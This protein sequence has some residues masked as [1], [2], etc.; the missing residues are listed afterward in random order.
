MKQIIDNSPRKAILVAVAETR[1]GEK[2]F[3]ELTRLAETAGYQTVATLFQRRDKPDKTYHIGKGKLS[4]LL[5]IVE[6]QSA[7]IVIFDDDISG[8]KFNNL[9]QFL[10]VDVIDR[11]T[12]ILEIF[13]NRAISGE[14]KLQIELAR[15]KNLLPRIIGKGISLSRQG[16]GGAGGGGARRG[17][18]E[19]KLEL[20]RRT[21]REEIDVLTEKI[22]K[23]SKER[24][25][26]RQKR[27]KNQIKT[28]AIVGYTNAGK[29][30][31]MNTLTKADVLSDDK[32][33]ATLDPISRKLWLDLGKEF[34]LVDTVGFISRLPHE[35]VEAFKST[36][37]EAKFADLLVVVSDGSS[38][39]VIFE[40]DSVCDTLDNIGTP[41]ETPRI[42][43]LNKCDKGLVTTIPN[44][45]HTVVISAKTGEG[46]DLLK[47]KI[48][49][50]LFGN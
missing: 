12:L 2:V 43:A 40:Y 18:G 6:S 31:L 15:N 24:D 10:N 25:L 50:L 21:L 47:S 32:L 37:E 41:A 3:A 39:S 34:L 23:L 35:L 33:F 20:D 44:A 38:E 26:R 1:D 11:K 5:A 8:S 14:G 28:V 19:Q 9:E 42:L 27:Q 46:I 49:S 29:S 22:A 16:G 48:S 7:D 36:L 17:G 30:T 45:E 4:E 13:A